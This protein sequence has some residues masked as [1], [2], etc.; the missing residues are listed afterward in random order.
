MAHGMSKGRDNEDQSRRLPILV[1]DDEPTILEFLRVGLSYEGY[2]VVT[3]HN[4]EEAIALV[5]SFQPVLVILDIMLPGMD[6]LEVCRRLRALSSAAVIMLTAK[7]EVEDRVIGLETGADDY[8]TKPF[9]FKELLARTK[10]VLRRSGFAP[11]RLLEFGDVQLNRETREVTRA[12][13]HI[14]LTPK[15]FDLLEMFMSQPGRVFDRET[16]L[17]RVWGY[18]FEGDNNT[19][20]VYVGYLRRKLDDNPPKLIRTVRGIGYAM[21]G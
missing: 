8:L 20:D 12:G 21:K 5:R 1:V 15:E 14:E 7:D 18:D 10:A 6:G 9:A 19:V 11:G 16:I 4:G 17:N 2:E 13:R 3:A